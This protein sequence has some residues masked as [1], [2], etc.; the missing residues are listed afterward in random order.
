MSAFPM[1][2]LFPLSLFYLAG[3]SQGQGMVSANPCFEL[4]ASRG[5]GHGQTPGRTVTPASSGSL[6]AAGPSGIAPRRCRPAATARPPCRC[7]AP[8]RAAPATRPGRAGPGAVGG[9][10]GT[11][12][13]PV[14][15]A[16]GG[17]M[18]GAERRAAAAGCPSSG[19]CMDRAAAGAGR[20]LPAIPRQPGGR[21]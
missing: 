14:R 4:P 10:G 7:R 21:E 17:P 20:G 12:L 5:R 19:G 11:G 8:C 6:L 1:S 16:A 9:R 2:P 15:S 3:R 18:R 13:G